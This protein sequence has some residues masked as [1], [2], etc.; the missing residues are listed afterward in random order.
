MSKKIIALAVVL[1]LALSIPAFADMD[2]AAKFFDGLS[3]KSDLLVRYEGIF[4]DEI[5][6]IPLTTVTAAT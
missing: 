1:S 5:S 6:V 3:I 2:S 4:D